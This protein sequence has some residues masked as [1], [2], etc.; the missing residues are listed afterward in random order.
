MI[1]RSPPRPAT[2]DKVTPPLPMVPPF[3]PTI[4]CAPPSSSYQKVPSEQ[5]TRACLRSMQHAEFQ[6]QRHALEVE[7]QAQRA[8]ANTQSQA[9]EFALHARDA[10]LQANREVDMLRQL[11]QP[12][13]QTIDRLTRENTCASHQWRGSYTSSFETPIASLTFCIWP[14]AITSF[15]RRVSGLCRVRAPK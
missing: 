10:V 6:A 9:S 14:L 8:V 11:L 15:S 5:I 1:E 13:D 4:W 12:R 7:A 2:P 3:P